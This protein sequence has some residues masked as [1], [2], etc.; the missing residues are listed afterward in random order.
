VTDRRWIDTGNLFRVLADLDF[1]G[2]SPLY[3]RLARAA[4]DDEEV[5]SLLD[6]AAPADRLPHLLFAAVQYLL[7]LDGY[8]PLEVF[9]SSGYET[10]RAWCLDRRTELS[11]LAGD[12]VLQTNDVGRCAAVLPCLGRIAAVAER[13]LA[14]IEVGASAGLNLRLDRYGY[15]YDEGV[16]GATSSAV[17]LEPRLEG[18]LA[19]SF[20][21]PEIVWRRG[22]D[23]RPVDV[24]NDDAVT[25]LR[26]CVWPE[27]RW[28]ADLLEAAVAEARVDPPHV[29]AGDAISDLPELVADAPADADLC[30][31]HTAVLGYLPDRIGFVSGLHE[32][33]RERPL[34]WVSGEAA[35]LVDAL[36]RPEMTFE[37]LSFLY[38]VVPIGHESLPARVLAVAGPHVAWLA[39][40]DPA[41]GRPRP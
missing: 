10:F 2:A 36:P 8:D 29:V 35:G 21:M 13:P 17:Q 31:L 3:E 34:W 30:I 25:W 23:R 1:H 38:G 5:V 33:G 7:F 4:A 28:R 14:L 18:G 39:W 41:S 40:L 20:A 11:G 12:H 27:Q 19:P 37:R 24:M 16:I 9:G 15:R 22:L 32:L 26:A 6:A